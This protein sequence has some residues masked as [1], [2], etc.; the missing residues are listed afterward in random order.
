MQPDSELAGASAEIAMEGGGEAK[1]FGGR[2]KVYDSNDDRTREE[3]PDDDLPTPAKP[4]FIR[5]VIERLW[6]T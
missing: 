5:R 3:V 1:A 6:P 4:T 2:K